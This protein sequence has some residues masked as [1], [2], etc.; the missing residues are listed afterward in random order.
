MKEI[1]G[2]VLK[3]TSFICEIS[4]KVVKLKIKKD[5]SHRAIALTI[6]PA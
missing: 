6:L 5:I 3:K 4:N 1:Q 2:A